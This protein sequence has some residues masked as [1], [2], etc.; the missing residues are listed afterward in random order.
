MQETR[1]N[2]K[3]LLEDIRDSYGFSIEESIL[4]ELIA[5]SL[6]SRASRIDF[7]LNQKEK[8][9]TI[10]DNGRGMKR[11]EI[12]EYHDI[13]AT[14]K[15]KG[16]G[17][18]FAGIGAKLSLL[19]SKAVITETKGKYGARAATFWYLANEKKAPWKFIPY[20]GKI[21]SPRGTAVT[22]EL[23]NPKSPLLDFDFIKENIKKHY[24]PLLDP[25]FQNSILKYIYKKGVNFFVN[26]QKIE[27][28]L[29]NLEGTFKTFRVVL[30]K[31]KRQLV[32]FGYLAKTKK[33]KTDFPG[34]GISTYG[35]VIKQGWD[36]LGIFPK[37]PSQ[38]YGLV[39]IP[40]LAEIL[41]TNKN[42]FLRDSS[43]LKKYYRYRKAIQE[44][45]LPILDDFGQGV[46]SFE[47]DLKKLKP[48]E[49]DIERTLRYILNDFPELTSLVGIK[50]RIK[51]S[52]PYPQLEDSKIE[53]LPADSEKIKELK[54]ELKKEEKFLKDKKLK[55][56]KV[57]GLTI[58]F[59]ENCQS[60]ELARIIKNTILINT[61]HPAYQKA[62]EENSEAYH[63]LFCVAWTFSKFIEENHSPQDF[64]SQ[65]LASWARKV[66]TPEIK[67]ELI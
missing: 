44:A 20:S 7:F 50:R 16:K 27:I 2:L 49:K 45:I 30:G 35:K 42:D 14:S 65:F 66:K 63:I 21:A 54:K 31:R 6:D 17:I 24:Y 43:S 48:L 36:W 22:I 61:F 29:A 60:L 4:T 33:E 28:N 41:T 67:K 51:D 5:N 9:F 47:K 52:D 53:I 56:E 18:G 46:I 10:C 19:I 3:H 39:E 58:S 55:R 8:K 64:I 59:E 34:I 38:I 37:I 57:P 25:Q 1:V 40:A 15:I 23:F 62:R 26:G 13:A 12:R 11:Q 32:G